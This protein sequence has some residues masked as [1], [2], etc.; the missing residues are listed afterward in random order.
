MIT[1]VGF[2]E[3]E[4]IKGTLHEERKKGVIRQLSFRAMIFLYL[5]EIRP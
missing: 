5:I 4:F 2:L 3:I 1:E